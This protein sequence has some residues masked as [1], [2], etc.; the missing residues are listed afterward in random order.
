M[1]VNQNSRVVLKRIQELRGFILRY[2]THDIVF[3]RQ[4]RVLLTVTDFQIKVTICE[5]WSPQRGSFGF[6]QGGKRVANVKVH[7]Q[8][9]PHKVPVGQIAKKSENLLKQLLFQ[10]LV[11]ALAKSNV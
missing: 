3:K 10:S 4:I 1:Q 7:G 2:S 11:P 6:F 8:T 5:H 9:L